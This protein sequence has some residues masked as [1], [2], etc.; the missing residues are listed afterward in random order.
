VDD[1]ARDARMSAAQ[2]Y[3]SFRQ[4]IGLSPIVY[5]RNQ[6]IDQAK[7]RLAE[8]IDSIK[9]IAEQVGY[10]DQFYFSRDFKKNTGV[11]PSEFRLRE[12]GAGRGAVK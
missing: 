6:R 7:R 9:E 12:L 3:R 5:L 2:F 1:L 10:S 11:S 8:S 4:E